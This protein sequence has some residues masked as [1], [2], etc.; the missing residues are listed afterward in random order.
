MEIEYL[1]IPVA[2]GF[3]IV[4]SEM[5][6]NAYDGTSDIA[7]FGYEDLNAKDK[8][9]EVMRSKIEEMGDSLDELLSI[10]DQISHSFWKIINGIEEDVRPSGVSVEFG[11]G[12]NAT[13][14]SPVIELGGEGVFKVELSWDINQSRYK[15]N[16]D[17]R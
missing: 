6:Q 8:L 1:R 17:M 14:K 15:E 4:K 7:E 13:L 12:F 3:I 5:V 16:V 11:L 9:Q 10:I 2:D